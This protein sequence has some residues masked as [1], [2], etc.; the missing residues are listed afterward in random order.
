VIT[1]ADVAAGAI[2]WMVGATVAAPFIGRFIHYGM[3]HA[4]M[5]PAPGDH[6]PPGEVPAPGLDEEATDA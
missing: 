5:P 3:T 4:P 1:G 2:L 6:P